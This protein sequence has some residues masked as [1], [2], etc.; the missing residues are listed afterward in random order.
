MKKVFYFIFNEKYLRLTLLILMLLKAIPT[1][2]PVFG[3]LVKLTLLWGTVIMAK[4][5]IVDRN[6][7]KNKYKF[8]LM[9]FI[10][11]YGITIIVNREQ[12]FGSNISIY[13]YMIIRMFVIY[14]YD[15]NKDEKNVLNELKLFNNTFLII[16]FLGAIA[17]ILL[18]ILNVSKVIVVG[19]ETYRIGMISGRLFG[20]FGNA[21]S[22]GFIAVLSI[23]FTYLN[24]KLFRTNKMKNFFYIFNILL[25]LSVVSLTGSRG[26]QISIMMMIGLSVIFNTFIKNSETSWKIFVK[27]L[28]ILILIPVTLSVFVKI[29]NVVLS[30]IRATNIVESVEGES[31]D[32]DELP[33]LERESY[34]SDAGGGRLRIWKGAVKVF[35]KHPILGVGRKNSPEM[36]FK[37]TDLYESF[38]Q[39][40]TSL[41]N[42]YLEILVGAG[43]VGFA[44]IM[45]ICF[46]LLKSF[47]VE[48]IKNKKNGSLD[49]R[50]I[51]PFIILTTI[52]VN[53]L[54]ESGM[55]L[56]SVYT[57]A[58]F[59]SYLSYLMYFIDKSEKIN[60]PKVIN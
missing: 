49:Y 45:S 7:L 18:V 21:N 30:K 43:I 56:A 59:W 32:E 9:L 5:I 57:S 48:L 51:G 24:Y 12:N 28:I 40:E 37:Y 1:L 27:T 6:I 55:V 52:A 35:S 42:E 31:I 15:E 2:D 33:E 50:L 11:F 26:A 54:V 58:I 47:F 14:K 44:I 20:A 53:N 19:E 39:V 16:T 17:S 4:D 36:I 25:Q 46:R 23:G 60:E 34:G 8:S 10:L 38:D 22:C 3:P 41:H 29:N 13:L